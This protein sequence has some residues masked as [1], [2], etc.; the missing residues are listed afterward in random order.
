VL[1]SRLNSIVAT[2]VATAL[3]AVAVGSVAPMRGLAQAA[4]SAQ[5]AAG[6]TPATERDVSIYVQL[7]AVNTCVLSSMKVP[8][9]KALPAITESI[10]YV[11][12]GAHGGVIQGANNNQ[13]LNPNQLANG[14]VFQM[15]PRI[16]QLCY[17]KL[18]AEDKTK[19]DSVITQI[20]NAIKQ[21][22]K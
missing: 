5:A 11:L 13:K 16:K 12:N 20:N 4:P 2:S 17:D 3:A 9:D 7:G 21:N 10:V 18:T 15:M 14:T 22:K 19:V 8:L 6:T 1:L